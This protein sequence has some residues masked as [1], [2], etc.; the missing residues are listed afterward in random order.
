MAEFVQQSIEEM[1]PELE[2]MERVKLFTKAETRQILKKRQSY[3]YK[4]RRRT[5][6]REDFLQYIQ[7][8]VNVLKLV[9]KRREGSGCT[10][11]RLEI[12]VAIIQRIHKLFRLV[13]LRFQ[14]D[15][16]LW[17]SH[18]EFCKSRNERSYV[19]RLYTRMLQVHNKK[20][21]LWIMAAKWEFEAN[22]NP[23]NARTLL[24]RGLRFNDTSKQ[25]WI[26]YYRLELLYAEKLRKRRELLEELADVEEEA[27]LSGKV[28]QIV[29]RK[30]VEQFPG[31]VNLVLAL[32]DVCQQF[33][34]TASKL[35]TMYKDLKDLYPQHAVTWN[36]LARRHL[37]A[38]DKDVGEEKCFMTF[39]EAIRELNTKEMWGFYLAASLDVLTTDT[40]DTHED[41]GHKDGGHSEKLHKRALRTFQVFHDAAEL[42]MVEEKWFLKWV[43]LLLT[44]TKIGQ[45]E[46]VLK[47]ATDTYPRSTGLWC[48]HLQVLIDR[49]EKLPTILRVFKSARVAVK[50]KVSWP[51]WE[52]M[53]LHLMDSGETD[54][55][56]KLM[57][58][59]ILCCREVSRPAKELYLEWAF[60]TQGIGHARMVYD[61]LV[62]L[63]PVSLDFYTKYINMENSQ[64][65]PKIKHL[66][67]AYEDAVEEFGK[68]H[69]DLWIDYL[70]QETN[71]P[72]GSLEATSK[73]HN[74]ALKMLSGTL[75]HDFVTK[76]TLLQTGRL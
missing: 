30:A 11:K 25:L 65:T 32:I 1:L 60:L 24:Q 72:R 58:E 8:E 21:D 5:K 40:E 42:Q 29:Y 36:A 28:A 23:E 52:L 22:V 41:K 75:N 17:L 34:F 15:V 53:L 35:N 59:A 14:D 66:L 67:R 69:P 43:E 51:V 50:E 76:H 46:E 16:K 39:N 63:K 45:V 3:E 64:P 2:Q 26:E 73:I 62:Q 33:P 44:S 54:T 31:D 68:S 37:Q 6:C 12:D 27:V 48:L 70:R 13:C 9:E 19:S 49:Q 71:H 47:Q 56:D 7:Y 38:K 18:I 10:Y 4:L 61:R 20:P 57:E 55:L 74:R